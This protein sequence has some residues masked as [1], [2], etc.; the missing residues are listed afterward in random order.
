MQTVPYVAAVAF[1]HAVAVG[2]IILDVAHPSSSALRLAQPKKVRCSSLRNPQTTHI[3]ASSTVH[4][5]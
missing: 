1:D 5:L 3:V 4:S 2:R